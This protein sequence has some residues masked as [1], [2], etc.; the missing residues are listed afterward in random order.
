MIS[1]CLGNIY[2]EIGIIQRSLVGP[3]ARMTYRFMITPCFPPKTAVLQFCFLFAC[4][5]KGCWCWNTFNKTDLKFKTRQKLL[6]DHSPKRKP[7]TAKNTKRCSPSSAM[8]EMQMRRTLPHHH[9][10]P[11]QQRVNICL[12]QQVGAVRMQQGLL[13][14]CWWGCQ[15]LRLGRADRVVASGIE[16]AGS[17]TLMAL[18]L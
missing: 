8:W 2:P 18:S 11:V 10:S 1:A 5:L 7:K 6:T 9:T 17:F 16:D 14:F 13:R 15:L 3:C 4:F 12:F